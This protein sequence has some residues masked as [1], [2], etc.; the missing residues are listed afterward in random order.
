[1]AGFDH[2]KPHDNEEQVEVLGLSLPLP[3]EQR[4]FWAEK[5]GSRYRLASYSLIAIIL[6]PF[7][8]WLLTRFL[9]NGVVSFQAIKPWPLIG[10][11]ILLAI[12]WFTRLMRVW[13]LFRPLAHKIRY[14]DFAKSYFAGVFAS[15]ITPSAVG[16]YP[17]FLF[18]LYRQGIS[19]GRS[20]AVSL[21]DS[22]N[23][24]LAFLLL[25]TAGTLFFSI[26][27]PEKQGWL[28]SA[29]VGMGL[30]TSAALALLLFPQALQR[31]VHGLSQKNNGPIGKLAP[32]AARASRELERL[33]L[34]TLHF[35]TDH[36][37]LLV[38][39]LLLNLVYWGAYLS[40][41]PLLFLAVG[42]K[43]PWSMIVGSQIATQF[44]Q[45]FIPTPGAAGGA[46]ITMALL[47]HTWL[48]EDRLVL[49]LGLWRFCTYYLSLVGTSLT[50]PWVLHLLKYHT[51][52][53][54]DEEPRKVPYPH[55]T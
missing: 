17:F 15:Q 16:G 35:W 36:R 28:P 38:S 20:L 39:N 5:G 31:L 30:L 4:R 34:V 22:V 24:G 8:L 33:R 13:Y 7:S 32:W 21:L 23:T 45:Y 46:E 37:L 3:Q 42:G 14:R 49:F 44:A 19:P 43:A 27:T 11:L 6:G 54:D 18:L 53:V 29:L 52:D 1:M 55:E 40:V 48:P 51:S 41:T 9:T 50:I 12:S 26:Y 25:L 10:A 47:V 2:E